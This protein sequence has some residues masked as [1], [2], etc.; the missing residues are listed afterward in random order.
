[1]EFRKNILNLSRNLLTF[2]I[3]KSQVKGIVRMK[4]WKIVTTLL[5]KVFYI[6]HFWSIL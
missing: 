1:M 5:V 3:R 2:K 4:N 6:L